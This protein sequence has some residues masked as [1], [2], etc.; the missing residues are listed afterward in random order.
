MRDIVVHSPDFRHWPAAV[1][2]AAQLA[3]DTHAGLTGLYV[4][5]PSPSLSG[6]PQLMQE[7]LA[8]AQDELQQAMLAGPA[9]ATWAATL[10]VREARWQVAQGPAAD[11]LVLAGQWSDVV[12]LQGNVPPCSIEER[13]VLETLLSGVACI[14]VPSAGFSP[15]R[16]ARAVVAWDGSPASNRAL[17]GALPLLV[18]ATTVALLQ[19][20]PERRSAP[21]LFDPAAHLRAHGVNVTRLQTVTEADEDTGEQLLAIAADERADLLVLGASGCR[22]PGGC[23]FGATTRVV[24]SR[25]HLPLYLR[26]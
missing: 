21:P 6:P 25:S 18:A 9:F 1:R 17:H 11:A 13:P 26:H 10:G 5:A 19:P 14:L 15:G 24:L 23:S 22:R 7:V 8:Y 16:V 4:A 3:A 2:Y 20:P 12:I